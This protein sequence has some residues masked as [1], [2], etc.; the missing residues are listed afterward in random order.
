[1]QRSIDGIMFHEGIPSKE[2][3][4]EARG[5]DRRHM[6]CVLDDLLHDLAN[7]RKKRLL[8]ISGELPI[9]LRA[10]QN[11]SRELVLV[12][13]RKYDD[14]I[15]RATTERTVGDSNTQIVKQKCNDGN[16]DDTASN[17]NR[18]D[19]LQRH[20]RG[21]LVGYISHNNTYS[22]QHCGVGF[23]DYTTLFDHS[24]TI[25]PMQ[26]GGNVNILNHPTSIQ[27]ALED[28]VHVFTIRP[29][30]EDKYDLRE[31]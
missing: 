19:S 24:K 20:E 13:K 3:L 11:M 10:F 7:D 23:K 6:I 21:H 26:T 18:V 22:C 30:D 27:S 25:H 5:D 29:L 9:I 31:M 14:L 4:M 17:F 1:M 16:I 2:D 8:K 28:A 12:P 15:R